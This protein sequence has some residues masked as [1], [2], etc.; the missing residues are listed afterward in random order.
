M[1]LEDLVM[2]ESCNVVPEKSTDMMTLS[3]SAEFE[4]HC[5]KITDLDIKNQ[6]QQ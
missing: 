4:K 2:E 5:I 6:K 1:R 3:I